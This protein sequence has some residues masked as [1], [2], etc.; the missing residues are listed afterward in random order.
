MTRSCAS[1]RSRVLNG[2]PPLIFEDGL[3]SRD[4]IHVSDIVR[5]NLLALEREEAVGQVYNVGTG[6]RATVADVAEIVIRARGA[7]LEPDV[8]GQYRAGDIRHCYADID[9]ISRDLGFAPRVEL[10]EGMGELLAW[11]GTQV[12]ED[13]VDRA[14]SEL[15]KRG[16]VR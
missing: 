8:P 14:R 3:Q 10:E 9:H 6:Q 13:R 7:G 16:L 2:N 15:E 5:A 11:L 4:F 12:A 1:K